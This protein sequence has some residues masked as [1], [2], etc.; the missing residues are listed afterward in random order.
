MRHLGL[1]CSSVFTL[2]ILAA[3]PSS[4]A[5]EYS[6]RTVRNGITTVSFIEPYSQVC[7]ANEGRYLILQLKQSKKLLLFDIEKAEVAKTMDCPADEVILA[8]DIDKLVV[9]VPSQR[10]VHRYSLPDMT[11]EK[12]TAWKDSTPPQWALMG[13]SS[14]GPLALRVGGVSAMGRRDLRTDYAPRGRAVIWRKQ[15]GDECLGRRSNVLR[16]GSELYAVVVLCLSFAR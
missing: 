16:L 5:V 15:D 6:T 4:R 9:V 10:I 7:A 8:A 13:C 3:P 14:H 2:I 1:V 12:T 11:C